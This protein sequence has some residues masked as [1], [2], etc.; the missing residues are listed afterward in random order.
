MNTLPSD[1]RAP[2]PAPRGRRLPRGAWFAIALA[3]VVLA[4]AAFQATGS[5]SSSGAKDDDVAQLDPNL[6]E[7]TS[8][9]NPLQRSGNDLVGSSAPSTQLDGFDGTP[10]TLAG[11]AG[12][13]V[14]LNFWASTCTPCRAEMP[15]LEQVHQANGDRVTFLGVDSGEG[16]EAGR[17]FAERSGTTYDLASDPQGRMIGELRSTLL[18]TT[19][20]IRADGT[21]TRIHSGSIT[22]DQLQNW[23][24]Q[25]L[26]T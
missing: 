13:P 26:L 5:S 16:M 23:I 15:A 8:T 14:V 2:E 18:P 6:T 1:D 24:Q 10:V 12:T 7:P 19:V 21:I 20:L 4:I 11:Y 25:D 17:S 9:T 22:A 3:I